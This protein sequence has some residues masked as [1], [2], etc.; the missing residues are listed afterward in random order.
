MSIELLKLENAIEEYRKLQ[1]AGKYA[2]ELQPQAMCALLMIARGHFQAEEALDKNEK[3]KCYVTVT[4]IQDQLRLSSASATRN[5]G[6]LTVKGGRPITIKGQVQKDEDGYPLWGDED[7]PNGLGLVKAELNPLGGQGNKKMLMLTDK[8]V[9]FVRQLQ[10][11]MKTD[12]PELL[13]DRRT[14]RSTVTDAR[15]KMAIDGKPLR[16]SRRERIKMANVARAQGASLTEVNQILGGDIY[17]DEDAD[18]IK[19]T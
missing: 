11:I 15:T 5:V 14:V 3:V 4:E 16:E 12:N 17:L 18:K 8:G 7:N 10:R 19:P 2:T 9:N 6:S 1:I 13:E